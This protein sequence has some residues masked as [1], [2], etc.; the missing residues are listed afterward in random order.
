[1]YVFMHAC[2]Y[3]PGT[4]YVHA[5]IRNTRYTFNCCKHCVVKNNACVFLPVCLIYLRNTN[6]AYDMIRKYLSLP[7]PIYF[8]PRLI[9]PHQQK[10]ACKYSCINTNTHLDYIY[11]CLR[12][13]VRSKAALCGTW[14]CSR[15]GDIE[16][17]QSGRLIL[18]LSQY[19][20]LCVSVSVCVCVLE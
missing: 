7:R 8:F 15:C 2:M 11:V 10:P 19:L 20:S 3:I 12:E 9:T 14:C 4:P 18:S 5:Y 13:V 1:M 17:E 6:T 16:L